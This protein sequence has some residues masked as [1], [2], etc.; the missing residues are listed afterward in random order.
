MELAKIKELDAKNYFNVFNRQNVC[1]THGKGSKVYDTYGA[2]YVD[3]VS[4]IAVNCL[5]HGDEDLVKAI[6]DQ[7]SKIIHTS[8]LY[9]NVPQADLA[10]KL[11]SNSIFEKVFFSNSGAEA[12]EA[13]IK[14]VRKHYYKKGKNKSTI[15]T[16]LNS[17]HGRTLATATA[18]GQTKYSAP[19]APLPAGFK[20]VPFNDFNA[21]KDAISDDVGAVMLECVQG[22]SGVLPATFDYMVNTYALLKSKGILLIIDEVQ[23]GVGRTGK[24]F[25]FEHYGI[26]PD[27]ITLAKGLGGGVPIGAMLARGDVANAFS[28]GDHGST[29]GG[30]PLACAAG[31]VVLSKLQSGLLDRVITAGERLKQRL[32]KF[33][34]YNFVLDVRGMGLLMGMQLDQKLLGAEVV[35]KMM[36]K[37]VLINC[38][39]NN[40]LRFA[41]PLIITN[42]EIDF[43]AEKLEEVFANTNI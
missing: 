16:A 20:Y 42:D 30:N 6:C 7:A 4:G 24:T 23:T 43:M 26:Q 14:L 22:E 31:N 39:G 40:T 5:G 12:N 25:A 13:A 41:P 8:N 34:K 9:Y 27:V 38:A 37:G 1:I 11:V 2:E 10:E 15:I 28:V 21:L 36:A 3:F 29:F 17:F 18:T 33:R 19:F 35:G 32:A